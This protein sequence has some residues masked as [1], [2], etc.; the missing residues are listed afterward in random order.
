MNFVKAIKYYINEVGLIFAMKTTVVDKAGLTLYL[1]CLLF[2]N[3]QDADLTVVEETGR[4]PNSK[5]FWFSMTAYSGV[6]QSVPPPPLDLS[7]VRDQ[8]A[9][10]KCP[11]TCGHRPA[12]TTHHYRRITNIFQVSPPQNS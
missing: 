7:P 12:S 11:P 9:P 4:T 10:K 3:P 6:P 5:Q 8:P 2:L 1:Y